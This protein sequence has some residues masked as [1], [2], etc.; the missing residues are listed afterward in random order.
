M[1]KMNRVSN[2][3]AAVAPSHELYPEIEKMT[4][5]FRITVKVDEVDEDGNVK[6]E[7]TLYENKE[8][9]F[10]YYKVPSLPSAL[11]LEGASLDD[12]QMQF[13]NEAL[14]GKATGEA[15][16]SLVDIYNDYLKT[17]AQRRQY[18][19]VL[20]EKTPM[21]DENRDNA[22]ASIVRN[23]VKTSGTSPEVAINT[24]KTISAVPTDYTVARFLAN[25][26]KR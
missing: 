7:K 5:T 26:G 9:P 25:K 12:S 15:V 11:K 22:I 13:L 4:G 1:K 3:T 10:E 20:N 6:G 14:T 8:E 21:T 18:S 16:K 2:Q 23:F 17:S 19:S 24:L